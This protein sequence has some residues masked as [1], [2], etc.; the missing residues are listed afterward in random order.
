MDPRTAQVKL[1]RLRAMRV[2]PGKATSAAGQFAAIGR[3]IRKLARATPKLGEVWER[4]C[5]ANLR[6][7]AVFEGVSRGT[8]R[9][10]VPDDA[11]R[12]ELMMALRGGLERELIRGT[13]MSIRRVRVVV[14]ESTSEPGLH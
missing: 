8:L 14:G 7:R 11:T 13:A 6:D 10:R 12:H 9:L 2:R 1:E 5:P 4:C 3:E